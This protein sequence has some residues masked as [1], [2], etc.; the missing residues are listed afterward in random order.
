MVVNRIETNGTVNN[1]T[2]NRVSNPFAE[3]S[4]NPKAL[5]D[6]RASSMVYTKRILFFNISINIILIIRFTACCF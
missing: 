1:I 6:K 3:L 4:S 2:F 5:H